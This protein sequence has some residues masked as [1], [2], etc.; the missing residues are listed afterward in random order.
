[1]D[2]TSRRAG[3]T[4]EKRA[5]L[6]KR[7]RGESGAFRQRETVTRCA[8]EGPEYPASFAQERMWFLTQ[9]TPDSPMYNVPVA[10]LVDADVDIPTLE[11]T[12][13]EIVRRHE[14]LRTTFHMV[15][16][17]LRQRVHEPFP[18]EVEVTDMRHRVGPDFAHDV[19]RLV[20]E[21]GARVFD[22]AQL[23]LFRVTLIRVSDDDYALLIS[24]QHIVIDGWAY[25][26]VL[27]E[28]WEFYGA[29][30]HGKEPALPEP[31]L[32][33][34]DFSAWQRKFLTGDTLRAQVDYWREKLADA[35]TL[36]LPT[37]FPRPPVFTHRGHFHRYRVRGETVE[38]LRAICR[39]ESV[40]LNMVL[41]AGF[42]ALLN[43]YS[44]QDDLVV[45]TLMGNRSRAE[46]EQIVGVFVNTAAIRADLSGDPS[47]REMVRAS[48]RGVL[49]A[50]TYQ[51]LPFEKLV[52]MLGVQRDL[53]RHPV[54]QALFFHHVYVPGHRTS[55]PLGQA[56]VLLTRP[57]A[58]D[59]DASLID[60]GVA[61]FDLM[62]ATMERGDELA[63]V[64][65]YCTDLFRPETI[66]RMGDHFARLLD[67][68]GRDPDV[69][70]SALSLLGEEER[71]QVVEEWNARSRRGFP[72]VSLPGRFERAAAAAP[73]SPAIRHRGRTVTYAELNA[74]ANRVARRLRAMGAGPESRVAVCLERT[75]EAA[76]AFLGV[77]KAGAAYVPLD[78][79]YPPARLAAVL[80]DAAPAAVVTAADLSDRLPAGLPR[81]LVDA[82]AAEIGAEPPEDLGM[83]I[84]PSGLAY[85]LY[86]S[87]STG[88]P[89]GVMVEHRGVSTL[90]AWLE[91]LVPAA[92]REAVLGSTS[93]SFDVSV[94]E[95]FGTLC[96]GGTLV[97]VENALEMLSLPS[98][99]R[100]TLGVMAPTAAAELLRQV[101]LPPSL[102]ALNL[103]GEAL[104]GALAD[105]L[106]EAGVATVRNLYGPTEA[107][108][109]ATWSEPAE[110]DPRPPIGRP[111]ADA[112]S[113]VLDPALRP[114]PPGV[115]GE[116]FLAGPGVARGY[117]GRP[118]MTAERFVP[119]P[120]A[121][122]PGGRMYRTG[123]R[124]RWRAEGE[125]EFL[126][127]LDGQIKL[128]GFRIELGDVESALAAHPGVAQAVAALR[129]DVPGQERLVGYVVP[130]P[131]AEPAAAELRAWVRER[132][133]EYMVP[134][135][136]VTLDA[137]PVGT[138][139]KA[140]RRALPAPDPE[141]P[142][143]VEYVAPRDEAEEALARIWAEVLRRERVGVHDNFFEL[144]G[145]SIHS[146]QVVSR[147]ASEAG[148]RLHPWQMFQH[149]T[150]AEQAAAAERITAGS[151]TAEEAAGD[152]FLGLDSDA[153]DSVLA[154][155][156]FDD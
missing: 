106:R 5:L 33:Y 68:A 125:L 19:D 150:V 7:L 37:D 155:L 123:D 91:E 45:G 40:T 54:F 148:L 110:G 8:G 133:P 103:G 78:P 141:A 9:F 105:Q 100:V 1:M 89:K 64:I 23:P 121:P 114:V 147:A 152:D 94:A 95:L 65:E 52:D 84:D 47:F 38:R 131:G 31:T 51:D 24:M 27:R 145:D 132:L 46:L 14:G 74:L 75:P 77:M 11:R 71:R 109:Y 138:T 21:L 124:A 66:R 112:R 18:V 143:S 139:G 69:R 32:R 90:L 117:A 153:M 149:Q 85:V 115:P 67:R 126:G 2:I 129:E 76:A 44:G 128:R 135:A 130:A 144:G 97:L 15:D 80:S 120:F 58:P 56:P 35:P 87:G 119:D 41:A 39:Q 111:V 42:N 113:Y 140:D 48:K 12:L 93:F 53:S 3:L 26:L 29:Y 99:E 63:V 43:K 49:E 108:V 4:D 79:S 73:S 151:V 28:L 102:A 96:A 70:L 55:V 101:A 20:A 34:A 22:L 118:G 156:G 17:E 16:G 57:I 137:V 62:M 13:T 61:K 30:L 104:P 59:H 6:Q 154:Q 134:A 81:L 122:E 72:F 60:T 98:E 88:T 83:E 36:D 146:I 136:F 25:P 86:T 142:A 127:R 82:Q 50:D 92:E 10:V 116:L 107:T